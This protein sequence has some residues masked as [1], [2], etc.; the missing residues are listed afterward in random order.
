MVS[1]HRNGINKPVG[2]KLKGLVG[3]WI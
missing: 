2:S 3:S 1:L